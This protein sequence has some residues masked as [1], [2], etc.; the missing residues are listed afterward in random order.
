MSAG[1]QTA[2]QIEFTTLSCDLGIGKVIM[3]AG[4]AGPD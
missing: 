1:A 3:R 2:A 4:F